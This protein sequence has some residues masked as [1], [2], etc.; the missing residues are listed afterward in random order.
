MT[1]APPPP[2]FTPRQVADA[3]RAGLRPSRQPVVLSTDEASDKAATYRNSL[4]HY[5]QH[6]A[7]SLGEGDY[8]QAAE[9]SW[10]A[11]TQ[12]HKAIAADHRLRLSHHASI[13]G[14]AGQLA[15][16]VGESDALVGY[17]LTIGLAFARSLHQHFYENDLPD[18]MV[19]TSSEAVTAA[20]DLLHQLFPPEPSL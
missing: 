14:V 16:L 13:I 1:A 19:T 2:Q 15:S 18:R 6:I 11:Y 12:A 4:A 3:I 9:K 10:G 5:R 8:R 20:I 7:K 17:R